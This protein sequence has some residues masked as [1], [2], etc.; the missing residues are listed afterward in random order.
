MPERPD[1]VPDLNWSPERARQLGEEVVGLWSD[2]LERLPELPVN[3]PFEAAAVRD[4]VALPVPDEPTPLP[5]L[6][7]HL[8]ELLFFFYI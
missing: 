4:A 2:L 3:R 7:A 6:V 5:D 8:R 1:P